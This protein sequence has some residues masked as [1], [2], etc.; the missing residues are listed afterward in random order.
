MLSIA[1]AVFGAPLAT[2]ARPP[3]AETM[4]LTLLTHASAAGRAEGGRAGG[5]TAAAPAASRYAS[6]G[7]AADS[8]RA[9][10]GG[11]PPYQPVPDVER[12]DAAGG[13]GERCEEEEEEEGSSWEG[14]GRGACASACLRAAS[15]G[16]R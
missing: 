13:G 5:S 9:D 10:A 1:L 15:R 7:E 11:E 12:A 2:S 16:Q 14:G 6:T 8:D 3:Q 4:G